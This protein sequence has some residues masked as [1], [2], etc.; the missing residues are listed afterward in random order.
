MMSMCRVFSCVVGSGCLLWPVF[1]LDKTLLAF[2]CF[3]LHSKAKLAYYSRY[4]LT[5]SLLLHPSL[6]LPQHQ[7]LRHRLGL[8][9]MVNGLPWKQTEIIL[10]FLRLHHVQ[11]TLRHGPNIIGSYA[12]LFFTSLDFTFTSK[13]TTTGHHFC[14]GPA[15]SFFLKL[16]ILVITLCSSPVAYW[17]PSDLRGPSSDVIYFCLFIMFMGFWWQEYWSS[18][19]FPFP[20][21]HILS[22]LF[23]LTHPS[24]VALHSMAHSFIEL[25]KP[26]IMTRLWSMKGQGDVAMYKAKTVIWGELYS[27]QPTPVF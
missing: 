19:L 8:Y 18:W 25:R 9:L 11:F 13:H 10:S 2:A 26:F 3:T 21:D 4:L 5:P 15:P 20:V 23:T 14:F 12:I 6:Q 27:W 1:S 24:W 22:E 7:W 17:T 16:L